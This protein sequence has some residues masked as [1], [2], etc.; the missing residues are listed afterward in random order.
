MILPLMKWRSRYRQMSFEPYGIGIEK[1]TAIQLGIVPVHYYRKKEYPKDKP[2]W[3]LQSQGMKTD[4]KQEAEYR[5]PGDFNLSD[6]EPKKVAY[7][8]HTRDEADFIE[9]SFGIRSY[10]FAG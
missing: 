3:Q 4:W 1:T 9:K 8:C 5:Y 6:I 2:P 10:A 7:F